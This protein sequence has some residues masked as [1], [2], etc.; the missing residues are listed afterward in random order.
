M[1]PPS[2]GSPSIFPTK[3]GAAKDAYLGQARFLRATMGV[4]YAPEFFLG[5]RTTSNWVVAT[6]VFFIFT[7]KIV[8]MIQF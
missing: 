4:N 8:E 2:K 5:G 3:P 1:G 7:P 6:Q